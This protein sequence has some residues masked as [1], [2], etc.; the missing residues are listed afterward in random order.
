MVFK[1]HTFMLDIIFFGLDFIY[2]YECAK[3]DNDINGGFK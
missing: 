3:S 1:R 2:F